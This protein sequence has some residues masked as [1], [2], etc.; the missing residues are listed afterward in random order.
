MDIC[1]KFFMISSLGCVISFFKF[2]TVTGAT[3]GDEMC[4]LYIMYYTENSVAR[5]IDCFDET[6]TS[7]SEGLPE[8]SDK[9]LPPNPLLESHAKH[10]EDT[11]V[12]LQIKT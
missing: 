6:M 4:N 5:Q 10:S 1:S 12:A 3:A 7:I 11:K 8:D 2:K 9:A